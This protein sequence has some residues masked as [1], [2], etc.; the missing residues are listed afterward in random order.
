MARVTLETD[1]AGNQ[2]QEASDVKVRGVIVGDVREVNAS[3][4]GATI[5]LAIN[6]DYLDQIPADVSA[7]LLP[8]TLFGERFVALELPENAERRAAG[9]RRRHR[10]GP[11]RE[12]HRAAEGHRRH[13]P[14]AAG[15]PAAGPLVHARRDR[16]RAAR[17]RELAGREPRLDRRVLRRD[18]HGAARA[19]GRHLQAGRLRRHLRRGRRRPARRPRQPVDHEPDPGGPAGAAAPHVHRRG[20]VVERHRGL[21]GDQ[22]AEPDLAGR[23]PRV[24]CSACSPSTRPSTRACSTA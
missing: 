4:D 3:A 11:Q 18:Q 22:R 10:P 13:A 17:P 20:R 9:R 1:T 16:R 6:P 12:R 7:R 2:L 24:R 23:R 19:A 8:K 21:P 5:E 15:R 14:A